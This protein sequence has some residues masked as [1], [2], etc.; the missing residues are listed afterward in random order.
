MSTTKDDDTPTFEITRY[1]LH[2]T[3]IRAG[4]HPKSGK[5]QQLRV[6]IATTDGRVALERLARLRELSAALITQGLSAE[7]AVAIKKA[8]AQ[9]SDAKFDLMCETALSLAPE[10]RAKRHTWITFRDVADDWTRGEL[11]RRFPDHVKSKRTSD[12][13]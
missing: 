9:D 11:H 3:R 5:S 8:A 1:G 6:T 10:V 4:R 7:A 13:D 2:S 12:R